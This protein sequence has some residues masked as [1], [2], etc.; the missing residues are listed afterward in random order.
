MTQGDVRM[1]IPR[2]PYEDSVCNLICDDWRSLPDRERDGA[3]GIA[4]V[5][6]V[7]NGVKPELFHLARHLGVGMDILRIPYKRLS[8]NGI[9]YSNRIYSD[10]ESLLNNDVI[11]WGYYSGYSSGYV[12]PWLDARR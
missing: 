2:I 3:I 11:T 8:L 6:S 4:I 5:H 9:F 7:L 12:G 10:R 1:I